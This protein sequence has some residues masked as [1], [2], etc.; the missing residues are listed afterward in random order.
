MT[1]VS[2]RKLE[3]PIDLLQYTTPAQCRSQTSS[4]LNHPNLSS[5][6]VCARIR[7][8]SPAL[9]CVAK[10]R[11][12]STYANFDLVKVNLNVVKPKTITGCH[13]RH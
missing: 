6:K 11:R 12:C 7:R 1:V 3:G 13:T 4:T 2:E 5:G 9:N 8:S 10:P